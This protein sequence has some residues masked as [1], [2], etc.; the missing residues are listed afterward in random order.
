LKQVVVVPSDAVER[1]PNGLYAFVVGD[2]NKVTAH[3]IKV[4][5][6]GNGQSVVLQGL[7]AGQKVVTAGQ[8]RLT[9]GVVVA[10][11]EANASAVTAQNAA[12]VAP[13]KAP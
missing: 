11:T 9:Q 5:Q 7:S 10:P 8:Y 3:D 2:D 4:G 6:E 12:P 13:A 1:G